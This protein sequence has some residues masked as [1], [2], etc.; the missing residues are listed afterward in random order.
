MNKLRAGI[1]GAGQEAQASHFPNFLKNKDLVDVVA[2]CDINPVSAKGAAEKF[3]IPNYYT[4]HKEMLEKENLDMVSI[5]VTNKFHEPIT[6][7]ALKAGCNVLCEKPPAINSV[8]AKHMEKV[9]KETGKILTYNL[10]YRHAPE[11]RTVKAMID[12]GKFGKIYSGK[13]IAYRRRGIP[14][15]GTFTNK[16]MQ[17]GGPMMDIGI[18]MLDTAL[19][20]LGFPEPS[21]VAANSSDL[22]GKR[23]GF[24]LM[25]DWDP[26]RFTVE[27]SMFGYIG[28]KNGTSLLV[29]TAFAL[30]CKQERKMNVEL[31]GEFS[32]ASVF[33][34]EV[35]TEN[36]NGLLDIAMPFV[37]DI[38][39]RFES[40]SSFIR[41]CRDNLQPL[42]T[43][44]QAVVLMNIIDAM[45]KSAETGEPV[46]L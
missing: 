17:G 19:Y 7:D 34:G 27:D 2:L 24:G 38:D 44:S 18:H 41:C 10:H 15:W 30:N 40:I 31:F 11:V 20:L 14:G 3:G 26:S 25:G 21:Y 9:A 36:E 1:I 37:R 8:Q 13:V 33:D 46:Q 39:R 12:E 16:D 5:C 4:S 32:G 23:K 35:Y 29:E 43:A 45:Y 28:F 22:I 42:V 6:V